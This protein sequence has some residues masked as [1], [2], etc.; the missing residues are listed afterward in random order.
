M[1][2]G[3]KNK[4]FSWHPVESMV[5]PF[6]RCQKMGPIFTCYQSHHS[7]QEEIP[8]SFNSKDEDFTIIN[9]QT[10]AVLGSFLLPIVYF[11]DLSFSEYYADDLNHLHIWLKRKLWLSC[12]CR[13][14]CFVFGQVVICGKWPI[15]YIGGLIAALISDRAGF[16]IYI[17]K[18]CSL[19][20]VQGQS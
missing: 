6:G 14:L 11:R 17:L 4:T 16:T 15:N 18:K 7:H 20:F 12:Q 10:K 9:T 1:G 3:K 19:D 8:A 13:W 5:K 2:E